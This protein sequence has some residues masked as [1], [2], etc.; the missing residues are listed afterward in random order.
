MASRDAGA[1]R[2]A[3][4][5]GDAEESKEAG[6]AG[7]S[8]AAEDSLVSGSDEE[9]KR[10]GEEHEKQ[11]EALKGFER[12]SVVQGYPYSWVMDRRTR[13]VWGACMSEEKCG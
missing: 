5:S 2:N 1:S 3:G 8:G 11:R 6:A 13:Y 4:A 7:D 10:V 9:P 12:T